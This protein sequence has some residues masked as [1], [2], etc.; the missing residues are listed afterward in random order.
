MVVQVANSKSQMINSSCDVIVWHHCGAI[1]VGDRSPRIAV[2]SMPVAFSEDLRWWCIVWHHLYKEA[3]PQDI[4][5]ALYVSERTVRRI[6][7]QFLLTGDVTSRPIVG[8]L[9]FLNS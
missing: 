5:E 3:S 6:V 8:R 9:K 4:A 2:A 1:I 7:A